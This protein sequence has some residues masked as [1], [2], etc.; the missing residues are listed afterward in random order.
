MFLAGFYG[1]LYET[2]FLILAETIIGAKA[3]ST[4]FVLA[5]FLM[6]LALGALSGGVLSK[7]NIVHVQALFWANLAS[8]LI[9]FLALIVFKNSFSYLFA[10]ASGAFFVFMIPFLNGFILPV[11]VRILEDDN[12]RNETGFIYFINTLGSVL[13]ALVA[14]IFFVPALGF[15]G[16][17]FFAAIL[18]LCSAMASKVL[19]QKKSFFLPSF[20]F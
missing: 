19:E 5:L 15:H 18:G 6:G 8:S 10:I 20:F 12:Q 7:K 1:L 9:G 16:S 2:V 14:G 3:M 4:S 17:M 11:A 13:G